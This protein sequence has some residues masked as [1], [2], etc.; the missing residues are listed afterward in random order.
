MMTELKTKLKS[1]PESV[2]ASERSEAEVVDQPYTLKFFSYEECF[3]LGNY[4]NRKIRVGFDI[5]NQAHAHEAAAKAYQLIHQIHHVYQRLR[6]WEQQLEYARDALFKSQK[7]VDRI[8]KS[9]IEQKTR[10][11]AFQSE[12]QHAKALYAQETI[13]YKQADRDLVREYKTLLTTYVRLV[14]DYFTQLAHLAE[15]GKFVEALLLNEPTDQPDKPD[16]STYY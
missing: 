14:D 11:E 16:L 2:P 13:E 3:N 5:H 4:D 15:Q 7:L 10:I 8:N 9:I 6:K 12:G 1:E